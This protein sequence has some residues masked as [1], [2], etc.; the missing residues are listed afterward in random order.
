M[1]GILEVH[2][3]VVRKACFFIKDKRSI[4]PWTMPR[5]PW[6]KPLEVRA[7]FNPSWGITMK[8][9]TC[10]KD[11]FEEHSRK[12]NEGLFRSLFDDHI[13]HKS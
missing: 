5:L 2:D 6:L 12:W 7:A 10:V 3:L 9:I 1:E 8:T 4:N 13:I 11:L